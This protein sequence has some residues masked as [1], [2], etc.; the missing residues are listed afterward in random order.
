MQGRELQQRQP[1]GR[2]LDTAAQSNVPSWEREKAGVKTGLAE[3]GTSVAR[4]GSDSVGL[5]KLLSNHV[6]VKKIDRNVRR[7]DREGLRQLQRI[8]TDEDLRSR[9]VLH[10]YL[11][12]LLRD[13]STIGPVLPMP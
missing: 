9:N 2:L 5:G 4:T 13:C 1:D 11:F 3:Q 6:A 7:F 10:F 8:V 12:Q